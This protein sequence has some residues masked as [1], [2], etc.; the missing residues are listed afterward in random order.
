MFRLDE[1]KARQYHLLA[2]LV[3]RKAFGIWGETTKMKKQNRL[4]IFNARGLFE[5]PCMAPSIFD[6]LTGWDSSK[7]ER[8][9]HR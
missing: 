8:E 1:D 5:P 3:S 6:N 4:F 2:W 7:V 9:L